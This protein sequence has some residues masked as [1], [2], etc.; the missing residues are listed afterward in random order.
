MEPQVSAYYIYIY[1][2]SGTD[3]VKD[4]QCTEKDRK[5]RSVLKGLASA[6]DGVPWPGCV[7]FSW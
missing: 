7:S 4:R 5:I 1:M 2:S 3:T 6:Y